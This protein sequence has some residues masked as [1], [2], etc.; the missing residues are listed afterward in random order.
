MIEIPLIDKVYG[1]KLVIQSLAVQF[2][3][4]EDHVKTSIRKIN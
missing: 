1:L 2:V 3:N 4:K